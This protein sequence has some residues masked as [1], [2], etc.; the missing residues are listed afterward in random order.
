MHNLDYKFVLRIR[1]KVRY[2]I[3]CNKAGVRPLD[4]ELA[5]IDRR[6]R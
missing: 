6:H 3:Q 4:S 2:V 5:D 1:A